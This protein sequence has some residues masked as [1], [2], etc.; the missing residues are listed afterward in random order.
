MRGQLLELDAECGEM[1]L[2]GFIGRPDQSRKNRKHQVFFVNGRSISSP[3]LLQGL[4]SAYR[5]RLFEG[6]FPVA[7]LFLEIDPAHLDVNIHPNKKQIKFDDDK[8]VREFVAES[9]RSLLRSDASIPS[10]EDNKNRNPFTEVGL[11]N[12]TK[13]TADCST[14]ESCRNLADESATRSGASVICENVKSYPERD[15]ADMLSEL[16]KEADT[17]QIGRAHV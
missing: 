16:R 5:E 15:I 2:Y 1:K 11:I 10:V 12:M 17:S 8:A 4:E 7:F 6:Q 13:K 3:T 14:H 9:I